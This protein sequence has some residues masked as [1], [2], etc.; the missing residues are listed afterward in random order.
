MS[1]LNPLTLTI[2]RPAWFAFGECVGADPELFFPTRG[3]NLTMTAA[4]AVCAACCVRAECLD[5]AQVNGEHHGVWGGL[6]E[7]E[8]RRARRIERP[9]A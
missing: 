7:R 3:D 1:D 2:E 9:A 8:R 5:Y 4:K 6:S